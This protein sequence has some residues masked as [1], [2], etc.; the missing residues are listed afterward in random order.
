VGNGNYM[1][2][3]GMI[4]QLR[5]NAQGHVFTLPVFLL[6]ISGAYLILRARWLKTIGPHLAN[7]DSLQIK[8]LHQG[9][10][11]TLQGEADMSM[12]QVQLHQ[13]RRMVNKDVIVEVYSMQLLQEDIYSFPLLELPLNM[14][15]K[16]ALL[17]HTYNK[18]LS[19]P[20][21]LPLSRSHVH[22]IPLPVGSNLVKVKPYRY[23]HS[24]KE[25]IEKLVDNILKEGLIQPNTNPFSS[26]IILVK[27]KDGSWRVCNDYRALK[28]ITIKDNFPI[29]TIDEFID[30]LYGACYFSKLG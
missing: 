27:K 12:Q 15:L 4:Q 28:A 22:S 24:Q 20:S 11:T 21:G 10:F 19:T 16:L 13:I 8:F 30:E 5:V 29:S 3:E 18:V 1:Q 17:L 7:Y 2:A 9:K 14:E 6:P 26:P 25:D 23:P